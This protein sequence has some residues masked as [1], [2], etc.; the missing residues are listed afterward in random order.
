[1]EGVVEK[2]IGIGILI[3]L[4][5][6]LI[7]WLV[8]INN[9]AMET[10]NKAAQDLNQ[11][12]VVLD[13]LEFTQYDGTEVYG[14]SLLN[15]IKKHENAGTP[16][17]IRVHN[18]RTETE[19]CKKANLTDEATHKIKEAK[20]NTDLNLYINPTALFEGEIVRDQDTEAIIGLKFTKVN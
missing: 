12:N 19:Y 10:G 8:G 13:E 14:S 4:L 16:I 2:W 3:A 20:K 6:L 17:N 7:G 18:G 15:F 1:M 11:M 9:D 5:A